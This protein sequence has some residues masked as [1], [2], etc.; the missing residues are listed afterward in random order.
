MAFLPEIRADGFI[1]D[2]DLLETLRSFVV[3]W[4]QLL[5]LQLQDCE[6][7]TIASDYPG[8]VRLFNTG[9]GPHEKPEV[10]ERGAGFAPETLRSEKL[11]SHVIFPRLTIDAFAGKVAG[12]SADDARNVVVHELAHADEHCRTAQAFRDEVL[13]LHSSDTDGIQVGRK[14]VWNEYYVCRTVAQVNP[15]IVTLLEQ[16]LKQTIKEFGNDCSTARQRRIATGNY[17]RVASDLWSSALRFFQDAARL[18]G[19][20]DGLSLRLA[21]Q[22]P[23]VEEYLSEERMTEAF[24]DLH[25]AIRKLWQCYPNWGSLR[26]LDII[27]QIIDNRLRKI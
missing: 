25:D 12:F 22:C 23:A 21:E 7:I 17:E 10:S 8:F 13:A 3:H 14:A 2:E 24:E 11:G 15:G 27:A 26:D 6:A 19:H 5:S 4:Q 18:L 1:L 16:S 9:F 20:L